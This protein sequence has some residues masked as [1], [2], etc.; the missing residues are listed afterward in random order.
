MHSLKGNLY[1]LVIRDFCLLLGSKPFKREQEG[2]EPAT[3]SLDGC[4]KT[5]IK[6][7]EVLNLK[8]DIIYVKILLS[9]SPASKM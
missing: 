9:F 2:M 5:A 3:P 1:S 7:G 8:L 4:I 6:T